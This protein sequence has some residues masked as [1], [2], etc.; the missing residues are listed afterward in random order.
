M[1]KRINPLQTSVWKKL[2]GHY[3]IMKTRHMKDMFAE[4]PQRSSEFSLQFEDILVDF[5]KN[6]ITRDTVQLLLEL[7]N[8]I[9]VHDAIG[10]LF[11]GKKIN[12]TEDRA[13]LHVA[14]RNRS[15][16]PILVGNHNVMPDVNAVSSLLMSVRF[17]LSVLSRVVNRVGH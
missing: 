13:V 16:T 14:L 4:D 7:A 12:E 5:S 17:M 9:N 10:Q 11:S 8:E 3:K 1:L 6:I 2:K 15:N